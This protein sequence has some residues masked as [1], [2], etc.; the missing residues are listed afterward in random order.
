[1]SH[2]ITAIILKGAYKPE[3]LTYFDLRPVPLNKELTLFH[4]DATYSAYWQFYLG[5]KGELPL[6][7]RPSLP[8]PREI[9]LAQ[10][11]GRISVSSLPHFAIIATD[12]F[13]GIGTQH[14]NVF[15]GSENAD[16]EMEKIN[17]ALRFL[18]VVAERGKD[19]FDTVGLS[20]I[21]SMPEY[22][23]KY[24]DL[25]EEYDLDY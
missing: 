22:L 4:I 23:E 14:A 25:A 21:R 10:I 19:E 24:W 1:M 20:N 18:G 17:Q 11:V 3:E 9:V 12:Y 15:I 5:T 6:A 7:R 13:G 2:M 16:P 8:F